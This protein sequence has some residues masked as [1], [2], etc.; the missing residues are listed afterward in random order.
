LSEKKQHHRQPR[1][2]IFAENDDP[3]PWS[4]L[5]RRSAPEYEEAR[6]RVAELPNGGLHLRRKLR[7]LKFVTD[8]LAGSERRKRDMVVGAAGRLEDR[9]KEYGPHVDPQDEI[10]LDLLTVATAIAQKLA[11]HCAGLSIRAGGGTPPEWRKYLSDA[12]VDA[13]SARVIAAACGIRYG[14]TPDR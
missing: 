7:E 3:P 5:L 8:K 11:S 9:I 14:D 6:A 12:E 4:D 1:V 10:T 2:V 13:D